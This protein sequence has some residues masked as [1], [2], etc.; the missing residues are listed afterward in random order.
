MYK[1]V[2]ENMLQ[3]DGAPNFIHNNK[4]HLAL[5]LFFLYE[6]HQAG[7]HIRSTLYCMF[8]KSTVTGLDLC[9][10]PIVQFHVMK[11]YS[12]IPCLVSSY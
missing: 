11:S 7:K 8:P 5:A 6:V 4:L 10:V 9:A 2:Q 1:H 12:S 3:E